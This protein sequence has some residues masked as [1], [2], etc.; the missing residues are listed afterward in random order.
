MKT[1]N[2]LIKHAV[3][4]EEPK[5]EPKGWWDIYNKT[6]TIP[7]DE[8]TIRKEDG[9]KEIRMYM[10]REGYEAYQRALHHHFLHETEGIRQGVI[11]GGRSVGRTHDREVAMEMA[12]EAQKAQQAYNLT[13]AKLRHEMS[14]VTLEQNLDEDRESNEKDI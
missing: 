4:I 13:I 12:M 7:M 8:S 1:I 11:T 14:K 3:D 10:D 5:V 6:G 9:E 2:D